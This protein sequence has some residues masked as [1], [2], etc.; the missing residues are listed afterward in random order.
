[1][2]EPKD[3]GNPS[4]ARSNRSEVDNV[5]TPLGC[6]HIKGVRGGMHFLVILMYY[7]V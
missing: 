1:M 7:F 3:A 6:R 2:S 4:E 5:Q